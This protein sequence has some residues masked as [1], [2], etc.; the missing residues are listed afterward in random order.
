MEQPWW[1]SCFYLINFKLVG[2]S[3]STISNLK[4]FAMNSRSFQNTTLIKM[5]IQI[6]IRTKLSVMDQYSKVLGGTWQSCF[7]QFRPL[8]S[9]NSQATDERKDRGVCKSVVLSLYFNPFLPLPKRP[10]TCLR[11]SSTPLENQMNKL[12]RI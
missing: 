3:I 5:K 11:M 2:F 12:F 10:C 1:S 4:H 7:P 8:L 6:S 9:H